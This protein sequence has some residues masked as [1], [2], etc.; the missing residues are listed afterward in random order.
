MISAVYWIACQAVNLWL[1]LTGRLTIKPENLVRI[2]LKG[3]GHIEGWFL[4]F[5][6]D[7]RS[8]SWRV[9][10]DVFPKFH[11]VKFDEIAGWVLLRRR[12]VL[13]LKEKT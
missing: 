2:H 3:G 1:L 11:L 9:R 10:G 7:N 8:V 5:E 13:T 12:Y 6:T 4:E